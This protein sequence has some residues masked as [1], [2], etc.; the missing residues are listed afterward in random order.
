[1]LQ[2]DASSA[3]SEANRAL[4]ASGMEINSSPQGEQH[5]HQYPVMLQKWYDFV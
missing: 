1:M 4:L 5:H 3:G 2:D